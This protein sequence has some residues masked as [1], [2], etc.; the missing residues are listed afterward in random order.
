MTYILRA[1][2]ALVALIV[3]AHVL[4][5]RLT[6]T[7]ADKKV[8]KAHGR[9]ATAQSGVEFAYQALD[10]AKLSVREFKD[11]KRIAENDAKNIRIAADAECKFYGRS[12]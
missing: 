4:L 8:A 6:T 7:F 9:V 5:L 2:R 10:Y 12:L 3:S 11:A 1:T